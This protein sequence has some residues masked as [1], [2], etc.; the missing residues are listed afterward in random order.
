[1]DLSKHLPT[2]VIAAALAAAALAVPGTSTAHP[3]ARIACSHDVSATIHGEHK[4]L[5]PGEYCSTQYEREYERYG[6]EC[7]RRYDPPRL[8]RR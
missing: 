1:M 3:A 2:A 5:G 4:C 7:S 8:R 6:F